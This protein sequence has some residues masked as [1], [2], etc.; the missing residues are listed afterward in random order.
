MR[1]LTHNLL[2]NPRTKSYPLRLIPTELEHI[3]SEYNPSFILNILPKLDW[4]VFRTTAMDLGLVENGEVL[5][6]VPPVNVL[7]NGIPISGTGDEPIPNET[8]KVLRTVH[9][10]LMDT[11]IKEGKMVSVEGDE[12]II[13]KSIPNMLVSAGESASG[14]GN[15]KDKEKEKEKNE[16][17]NDMEN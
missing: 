17:R 5:P 1:I 6:E 3:E 9:R 7:G 4:P 10:I 13:S 14:S 11:H 16:N 15:G 12:Y 2:C 8:E